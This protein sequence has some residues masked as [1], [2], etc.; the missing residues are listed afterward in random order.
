MTSAG[1]M[2]GSAASE[3]AMEQVS[4][5]AI[6]SA[7]ELFG[8]DTSEIREVLDRRHVRRVPLTP[9]YIGGLIPYRGEIL[10]AVSLR[11][12]LGKNDDPEEVSL[13]VLEDVDRKECFGLMVDSVDGV[14]TVSRRTLEGNP[15]TLAS[16]ADAVF[17]GAYRTPQGLI[18]HLDPRR[19]QPSR[20][21]R[22]GM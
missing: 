12:L 8:I 2:G 13:V 10:V 6:V 20:L 3:Y 16:R 11:A 5:C 18:V 4:L 9:A 7:G 19:L 21:A 14:R 17:A 1:V 15:C 22:T